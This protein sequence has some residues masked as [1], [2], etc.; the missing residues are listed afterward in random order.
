[1][2]AFVTVSAKF[3]VLFIQ[4]L[5]STNPSLYATLAPF[6]SIIS[7]L[8]VVDFFL[9]WLWTVFRYRLIF[10]FQWACWLSV[11]SKRFI[12]ISASHSLANQTV[13]APITHLTVLYFMNKG[14]I[15]EDFWRLSTIKKLKPTCDETCLDYF[16]CIFS[17]F[18]YWCPKR[19]GRLFDYCFR[20]FNSVLLKHICGMLR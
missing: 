1:M 2:L 16:K 4:M 15:I 17:R 13:S 3:Y 9:R 20:Y 5:S 12:T 18:L 6:S 7:R 8:F 19:L 11:W 14:P 10:S